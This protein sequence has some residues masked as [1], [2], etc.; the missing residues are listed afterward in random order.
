MESTARTSSAMK[1]Q[2]QGARTDLEKPSGIREDGDV[3][4]KG[5]RV[6]KTT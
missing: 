5:G 1:L 6:W 3:P 2:C 4:V